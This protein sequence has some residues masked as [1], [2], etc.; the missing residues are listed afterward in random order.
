MSLLL[1]KMQASADGNYMKRNA[2]LFSLLAIEEPEAHLHP[3]MQYQFL[4]FL[5]VNRTK[6]NVSQ[7]FVTT[8]STQIVSAVPI[9]DVVCLHV[10]EYGK[11]KAGYPHLI[12][13]DNPGDNYSKAFVQRFLDATRSDIFFANKLIF[14]E[15]I[16]EELLLSTFAKYM[17]FDLAKEHVLVVNMGGR[18]FD[19]FLK[20]FDT[21]NYWGINKKVACITDIDPCCNETACYPYEYGVDGT[22]NYTHHADNELARFAHHPNIHYFRQDDRLGKTLEYDIMRENPNCEM[23]ILSGMK[24]EAEL[25]RIMSKQT[26]ADKLAELRNSEENTRI[27]NSLNDSNWTESEKCNALIASRY[28]NSIGKGG[29]ALA[30]SLVL[31]ENLKKEGVERKAFEVPQYI[32]EALTWLFQ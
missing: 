22:K 30:L 13:G 28:L 23:L 18:Y 17:G 15:G 21:T 19:H 27:A 4:N 3:A 29:N 5:D 6:H 1:A 7:I 26:L 20:M 8:H 9:D 12:Y 14:V 25:R 16:A 11:I 32:K 10:P 24:N 31:E 2:K